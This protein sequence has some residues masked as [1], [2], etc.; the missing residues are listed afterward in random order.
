[1]D[2]RITEGANEA[3]DNVKFL[4]TLEKYCDPLYRSDPV[5]Q[6]TEC[7]HKEQLAA[8]HHSAFFHFLQVSMVDSLPGLINAIRMIHSYSR[9]YNTAERMTALFVKV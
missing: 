8:I 2:S 3:K 9:H 6:M 1:M 5:S 4:H 7:V